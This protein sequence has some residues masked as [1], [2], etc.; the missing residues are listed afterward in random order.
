[1]CSCPPIV[2]RRDLLI[3]SILPAV[4]W[5]MRAHA[6]AAPLDSSLR[7][8]FLRLHEIGHAVRAGG[9]RTGR[10]GRYAAAVSSLRCLGSVSIAG[11]LALGAACAGLIS[12]SEPHPPACPAG[13]ASLDA[14]SAPV[15]RVDA[16]YPPA[17]SRR[18]TDGFVCMNFTVQGDGSVSDIC[19]SEQ[20]PGQLFDRE[21][22]AALAQWK[23]KPTKA[24]YKSGT[25]TQF[26]AE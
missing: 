5:I 6:G 11:A 26:Y 13:A 24:P 9:W 25:C 2:T 8:W 12:P 7:G 23:F 22:A 19:V 10:P 21:A 18:G 17:A 3:A 1:M 4:A 16:K 20:H 15:V 14:V